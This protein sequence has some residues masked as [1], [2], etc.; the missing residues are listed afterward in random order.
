ME[1]ERARIVNRESCRSD[2]GVASTILLD[3]TFPTILRSIL[4]SRIDLRIDS[5]IVS[6]SPTLTPPIMSEYPDDGSSLV[7][8]AQSDLTDY[9]VHTH[10]SL[11]GVNSSTTLR[12]REK[13]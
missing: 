6:E 3:S 11:W 5:R 10:R 8:S 13:R 12:V 7:Q 4:A 2:S 9:P 1:R